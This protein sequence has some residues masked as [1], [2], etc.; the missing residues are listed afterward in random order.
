MASCSVSK[1]EDLEEK[2]GTRFS[3]SIFG[4]GRKAEER[5]RW[6]KEAEELKRRNKEE[7]IRK[8]P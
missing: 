3:F 7:W 8:K 5:Q 6:E 4:F 1:E 2:N